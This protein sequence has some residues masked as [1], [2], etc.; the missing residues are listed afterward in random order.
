MASLLCQ[1]LLLQLLAS[2]AGQGRGPT[3]TATGLSCHRARYT[4]PKEPFPISGP[5]CSPSMG[6][7]LGGM[8][9]RTAIAC[10]VEL[11]TSVI[12]KHP[13]QVRAVL[14]LMGTARMHVSADR[15][16]EVQGARGAAQTIMLQSDL[17]QQAAHRCETRMEC[18]GKCA[19]HLW[20]LERPRSPLPVRR[21]ILWR[22]NDEVVFGGRVD[23]RRRHIRRHPHQ[24]RVLVKRPGP[25]WPVE[26]RVWLSNK[27]SAAGWARLQSCKRA[28][29]YGEP[30]QAKQRLRNSMHI[31]QGSE[32]QLQ[33][34]LDVEALGAAA[35]TPIQGS[36][37][38]PER[39]GEG[40]AL[41]LAAQLH[42]SYKKL[43]TCNITLE[44][45]GMLTAS[46]AVPCPHP[47]L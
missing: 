2:P 8:L 39:Q 21:R 30:D 24:L 42:A 4:R 27:G 45:K 41:R 13:C 14:P 1:A 9:R 29:D 28:S 31:S 34:D 17:M 10:M 26:S 46:S 20:M 37:C 15:V 43:A 47:A 5:S 12:L 7:L 33:Q 23:R 6:T 36:G 32:V 19:S 25:P 18:N 40:A 44:S 35:T 11:R 16:S 22:H 3:F 38:A